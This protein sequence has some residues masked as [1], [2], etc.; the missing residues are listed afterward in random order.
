MFGI[1]DGS[2]PFP[3]DEP[4]ATNWIV[5]DHWINHYVSSHVEDSQQCYIDSTETAKDTWSEIRR[6]HGVSGKGRLAPLMQ[7]YCSYVK[8]ADETIDE[9]ASTI[10]RL[11]D[12]IGNLAVGA[13]P[14]DINT[15]IVLMNACQGKEYAMAK[16][17]LNQLD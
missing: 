3:E 16:H 5:L 7:T 8:G 2:L 1:V 6:V 17:T 4:Q 15:A 11:V 10:R 12:D 9:M 14:S 13:R